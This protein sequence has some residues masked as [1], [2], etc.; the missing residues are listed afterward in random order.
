MQIVNNM[1]ILEGSDLRE[2]PVC[3]IGY[4]K[5]NKDRSLS[6]VSKEDCM[7]CKEMVR[8]IAEFEKQSQIKLK[9]E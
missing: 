9:T 2:Y 4:S 3:E 7:H 1:T 5:L 6:I 8:A